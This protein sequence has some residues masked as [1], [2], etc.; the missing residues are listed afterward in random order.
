MKTK[1]TK[2]KPTKT[3]PKP[4]APPERLWMV[5]WHPRK[6]EEGGWMR[7]WDGELACFT[8]KKRAEAVAK[9]LRERLTG[10]F[11]VVQ[12]LGPSEEARR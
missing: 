5:W 3:K 12:V 4:I 10:K 6:G 8:E 7:G 9:E 11:S 2:K 1:P